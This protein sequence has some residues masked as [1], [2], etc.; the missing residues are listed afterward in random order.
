L[1]VRA[2]GRS[3]P[4]PRR[5]HCMKTIKR[6]LEELVLQ[7]RLCSRCRWTI[8]DDLSDP[9][10]TWTGRLAVWM[11]WWT[12]CILGWPNRRVWDPL[13]PADCLLN[14]HPR[15]APSQGVRTSYTDSLTEFSQQSV[16]QD[17]AR[18]KLNPYKSEPTMRPA[19]IGSVHRLLS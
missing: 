15:P 1:G 10:R 7:P 11:A 8:E 13:W 3:D 12:A 18:Y 19:P 17:P 6:N 9:V 16:S 2:G 14:T 5:S 4:T